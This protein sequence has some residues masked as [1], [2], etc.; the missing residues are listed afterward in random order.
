MP[1]YGGEMEITMKRNTVKGIVAGALIGALAVSA[2]PAIASGIEAVLNSVNIAI[3]GEMVASENKNYVLQN[4]AEVPYSILYEGTT[5]LPVRKIS[6]L[7]DMQIDWDNDTR[8]VL[9]ETGSGSSAYDSWGGAP[10]FGEFYGIKE[11]SSNP[12]TRSTTH[13]YDI[14]DVDGDEEYAAYLEELG[15]KRVEDSDVKSRFIVYKKNST[16]VWLDLG[17]YN[18]LVYGVTVVDT[19]RPITGR[20]YSYSGS[21]EDIPN[22][23]SAFGYSGFYENTVEYVN[24]DFHLWSCLPDYIALLEEEGFTVSSVGKGYYGKKLT[25][26]KG[27]STVSI[28]FNGTQYSTIPAVSFNY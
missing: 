4:G 5:Y 7:L 25:L 13:W 3:N 10:D 8:T 28:S 12:T 19:T 17:L 9:L 20:D 16:E 27:R 2:V 14:N 15:F 21:N 24:G 23:C 1:P 11:I 6:E 22:F 26:K 18:M